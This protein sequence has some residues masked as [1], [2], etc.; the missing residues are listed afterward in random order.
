VRV[1]VRLF[2]A[3]REAVGTGELELDLPAGATARE[4]LAELASASG[5]PA[6]LA[7]DRLAIAINREYAR[8]DRPLRDGDELAVIPPVSGGSPAPEPLVRITDEPLDLAALA[9]A[10]ASPRAG[11]IV[12]FQGTTREVARLDYEA[13]REMA[14]PVM[15][16]ILVDAIERHGLLGAGAEH[17]LGSVPLGE[18]SVIVAVAAAH[19]AEAFAGAREAIDRIKAEAPIWKREVSAAGEGRWVPGSLPGTA[20]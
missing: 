8:D 3:A 6:A 5:S 12:T 14:E 15:R 13:Y 16:A 20:R 9:R 10:V 18:P 7:A 11:A 2:A 17:R 1:R 19:R 4:A